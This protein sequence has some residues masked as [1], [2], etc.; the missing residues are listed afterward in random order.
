M[1]AYVATQTARTGEAG[2]EPASVPTWL[3]VMAESRQEA[4]SAFRAFAGPDREVLLI[5]ALVDQAWLNGAGLARGE[6]R[7]NPP[8]I[9]RGNNA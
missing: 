2:K 3:I 5:E 4:L 8:L 7:T 9:P 6:V 1:Q